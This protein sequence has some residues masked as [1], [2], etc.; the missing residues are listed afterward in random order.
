ME[1]ELKP[2]PGKKGAAPALA[3]ILTYGTLLKFTVICK[4]KKKKFGH[5][6]NKLN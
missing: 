5:S 6:Y 1:P 3:P 4:E 2:E